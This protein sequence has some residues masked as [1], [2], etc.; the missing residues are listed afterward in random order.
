MEID[1]WILCAPE[2]VMLNTA[3]YWM[4]YKSDKSRL[5]NPFWRGRTVGTLIACCASGTL[6]YKKLEKPLFP[7]APRGF[8]YG[9]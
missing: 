5:N 3:D 4:V 8:P 7:N 9:Y 1:T 2:E 6:V